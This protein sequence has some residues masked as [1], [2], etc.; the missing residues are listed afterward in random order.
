MDSY[1]GIL[2][3]YEISVSNLVCVFGSAASETNACIPFQ[4][5]NLSH[6]HIITANNIIINIQEEA[7]W[8]LPLIASRRSHTTVPLC[9]ILTK[10][11]SW[12]MHCTVLYIKQDVQ[13]SST[14]MLLN[15]CADRF[16][17]WFRL[18][19]SSWNAIL[20][21]LPG[22]SVMPV[23]PNQVKKKEFQ[24]KIC[25]HKLISLIP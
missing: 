9:R 15:F 14:E 3:L 11:R 2:C 7:S 5:K 10:T 12:G 25:Q 17:A 8:I 20:Q 4:I 22:V 24:S 23:S 21:F 1:N 6:S 19:E 18:L 16:I 13:S